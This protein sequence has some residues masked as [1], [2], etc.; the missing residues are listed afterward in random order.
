MK[1]NEQTIKDAKK[2]ALFESPHESCGIV[3]NGKYIPCKNISTNPK[4]GLPDT[5]N[6][7]EIDQSIVR[8]YM[9]KNKLDGIIHSHTDSPHLSLTDMKCQINTNIPWMVIN[10][11][12]GIVRH[13]YGYGGNY[14]RPELFGREF[15]NGQ[16]DCWTLVCDWYN[17]Q[18]IDIYNPP[19]EPDW[20][21]KN[22]KII[23]E[24]MESS[25]FFK[26]DKESVKN[27]DVIV[28]QINSNTP[29]HTGVYE[30]GLIIHHLQGRLSKK[31]P[32]HIWF[33]Y[34]H[35]YWR[36]KNEKDLLVR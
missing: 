16:S 35:S 4:T 22:E 28:L 8:K 6:S 25:E 3:S 34:I 9:I 33:K 13:C 23:E 31:E 36:Y 14:D 32:V 20:W 17:E 21:R 2:H 30:D 18:G 15:I 11:S 1:F 5:L 10:V 26:I 12:H 19:R 7:F 24:N 29:N 27:G